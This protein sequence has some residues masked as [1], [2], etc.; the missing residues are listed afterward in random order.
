MC[1]TKEQGGLGILNLDLQN[2]SLLC[3]WLFRLCNE[4]GMWQQL[5]RNK[6]LKNNTLSQVCK[7][8]GDS[9]FW[10]G[11]MEIKSQFLN[12]GSFILKNGTQVSIWEDT[13]LGDQPL[14]Y[15]YPSVFNI[16]R[17]KMQL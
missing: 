4:D 3:K 6:Y 12:L 17:K 10:S 11:L 9:Q 1:Q 13:W 15:Q 5:I 14:K 8:P 2:K 16:V 7:R